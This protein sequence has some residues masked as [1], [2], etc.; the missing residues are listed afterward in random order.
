MTIAGG[1][2]L[3]E[4]SSKLPEEVEKGFKEVTQHLVGASYEAVLYVGSQ[5]VAGVNYMIICKQILSDKDAAEHLI[6][7]VIN[8]FNEKWSIVSIDE[9]I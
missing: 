1:W 8:I 6:K 7:L 3:K 2:N 9:I 4:M 5:V